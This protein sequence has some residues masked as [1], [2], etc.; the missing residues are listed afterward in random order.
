M[1]LILP[2]GRLGRV[3]L[4]RRVR[5][6]GRSPRP[7]TGIRS[8]A[9]PPPRPSRRRRRVPR[10]SR[11]APL[12]DPRAAR[13]G[14]YGSGYGSS[15]SAPRSSTSWEG[16]EGAGGAGGQLLRLHSPEIEPRKMTGVRGLGVDRA[17]EGE[18]RERAGL[19][20]TS[21]PGLHRARPGHRPPRSQRV[22]AA[23][24]PAH[25][26]D[27]HRLTASRRSPVCANRR[28]FTLLEV[29]VW[30]WPSSAWRCWPSST[31]TPER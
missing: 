17:P 30:R 18:G 6:S 22:D 26:E 5:A 25:R 14:G 13:P 10:R 1:V 28:G 15:G 20:S 19:T 2:Q 27:L 29:V 31:S 12:P 11:D 7:T 16:G 24:Q 4:P 9:T 23:D 21:S 3:L 8:C